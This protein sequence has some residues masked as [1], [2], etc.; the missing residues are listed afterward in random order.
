V[1]FV[2]LAFALVAPMPEAKAGELVCAKHKLYGADVQA[3]RNEIK[4]AAQ[5]RQILWNTQFSCTNEDSARSYADL[6][7]VPQPDGT[8][9]EPRV[10]CDR[11]TGPWEC[12]F[13]EIR[14]LDATPTVDGKKH[15]VEFSLP[16]QFD[17][18]LAR[19]LIQRSAD[20]GRKLTDY[21]ECGAPPEGAIEHYT[22]VRLGDARKSFGFTEWITHAE[23]EEFDSELRVSVD[24]NALSFAPINAAQPEIRFLCWSMLIVL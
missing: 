13:G 1:S 8:M 10:S 3:V 20:L 22:G 19:K 14:T 24:D 9:I 21:Q 15:K 23:I 7:P 2:A 16:M 6:K 5:G 17:A 4:R 12:R 18:D 11:G